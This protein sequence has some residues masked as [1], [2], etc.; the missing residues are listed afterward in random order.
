MHDTYFEI[1]N[2]MYEMHVHVSYRIPVLFSDSGEDV[3]VSTKDTEQACDVCIHDIN[4]SDIRILS[5]AAA[6][7][8]KN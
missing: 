6:G 8:M 2:V 5:S 3:Y 4:A 1:H 7:S